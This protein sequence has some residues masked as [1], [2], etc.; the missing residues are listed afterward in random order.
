MC[1]YEKIHE[2]S[3]RSLVQTIEKPPYKTSKDL[4]A[5]LEQSGVIVS[6]HT[7]WNTKEGFYG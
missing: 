1:M 5:D 4:K 2:R 7:I 3:L 6:S